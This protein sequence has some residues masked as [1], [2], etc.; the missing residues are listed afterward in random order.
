MQFTARTRSTTR[1]IRRTAVVGA[2]ACALV[3]VAVG[4]SPAHAATFAKIEG[5]A[6]HA[7]GLAPTV[8]AFRA[9]LGGPNN[10]SAPGWQPNGRREINWDGVQDPQSTPNFM[11][12]NLFNTAVPRGAVF[13]N[14][15][16][17]RFQVSADNNNPTGTPV[18]FANI[19]WQNMANFRTFSPQRLFSP[20]GTNVTRVRFFKP[21]TNVPATVRGFGAV[22]ADVDRNDSTKVALYDR[23]GALI[24]SK[25]VVK[26]TAPSG[27]LSFLGVKSTADI[28]EV[29]IT[30]GTTPIGP[31]VADGG[32]TDLVVLD[33]LLYSEPKPL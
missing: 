21:G 14:S 10:G 27:S 11:P 13:A 2:L 7:G 25:H 19:R 15:N 5:A 3:P 6:P 20:I 9:L 31:T 28:Y 22:F 26:G 12:A 4:A 24:W 33:D 17:N 18:L 23:W 8:D 32:G 30:T 29:R 16:N 1:R